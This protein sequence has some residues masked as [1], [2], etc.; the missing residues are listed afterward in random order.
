[1][2]VQQVCGR[3]PTALVSFEREGT[4]AGISITL[5]CVDSVLVMKVTM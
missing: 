2:G 1:M 3:A 4:T 5:C